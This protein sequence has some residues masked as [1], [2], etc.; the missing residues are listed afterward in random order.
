MTVKPLPLI[1]APLFIRGGTLTV[2]IEEKRK[3]GML[4]HSA[5]GKQSGEWASGGAPA[6]RNVGQTDDAGQLVARGPC[7]SMALMGTGPF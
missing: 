1:K 3:R 2:P 4:V 5:R 7:G 6:I